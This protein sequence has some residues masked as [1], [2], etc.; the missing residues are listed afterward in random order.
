MHTTNI[1]V[2]FSQARSASYE[3]LAKAEDPRQLERLCLDPDQARVK[4]NLARLKGTV[5]R[6]TLLFWQFL[7]GRHDDGKVIRLFGHAEIGK[8]LID[9][10]RT[11]GIVPYDR[12]SETE[13]RLLEEVTEHH[14]QMGDVFLGDA[15]SLILK[16]AFECPS[17]RNFLVG[18]DERIDLET[19]RSFLDLWAAFTAL[20][21]SGVGPRG[22]LTNVRV[23][24]YYRTAEEL[25]A[26]LEENAGNYDTALAR[27]E[28]YAQG[29]SWSRLCSLFYSFDTRG[30]EKLPAFKAD[31]SHLAFYTENINHA[32]RELIAGEEITAADWEQFLQTFHKII[33]LP[34][35][36]PFYPIGW[37]NP[38][39]DRDSP[40]KDAKIY[41][42]TL[43]LLVLLNRA[44][45][46]CREISMTGVRSPSDV[47]EYLPQLRAVTDRARKLLEEGACIYFADAEG[48]KIADG[49][50]LYKE[51]TSLVADLSPLK[52]G[53]KK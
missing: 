30:D 49:P 29:K 13:K 47:E 41:K 52:N 40:Q 11:L 19:A 39:V 7:I 6:Q 18:A 2:A 28:A 9:K 14:T 15:S 31:G 48:Q 27:I 4:A 3:D 36:S 34:Y 21:C 20:D 22:Y 45:A 16:E 43:K 12:L 38:G 51:K 17:L 44:A 23:E 8:E 5:S 53:D 32:V 24:Y 37:S 1:Y 33:E 50:V 25:Y 35:G 42:G 26:I 46:G 10:F